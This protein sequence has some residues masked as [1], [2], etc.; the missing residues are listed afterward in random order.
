MVTKIKERKL[1]R[2][3][4]YDYS[5]SG[6]YFVTICTDNHIKHFG[7]IENDKIVLTDLGKI[8]KKCWLDIPIHFPAAILD[9]FIIM[10]NHVHGIIIIDYDD[11]SQNLVGTNIQSVGNENIRSLQNNRK[12]NLSSIIKGF[13]VGVTKL[14]KENKFS[15]FKWQKSFYDRILRNEKELLNIR[16]YIKYNPLKEKGEVEFISNIDF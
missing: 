15:N 13:K 10:P 11:K 9:Q 3:K 16:K 8:V 2:L 7:K 4:N 5:N 14:A 1:N 6:Y 12:T